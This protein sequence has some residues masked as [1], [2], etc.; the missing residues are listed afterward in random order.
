[1]SQ[2]IWKAQVNADPTHINMPKGATV[3]HAGLDPAEDS[4]IWFVCDPDADTEVRYFTVVGTGHKFASD[5]H[6][7]GTYRY[8]AWYVFHILEL[9]RASTESSDSRPSEDAQGKWRLENEGRPFREAHEAN[10]QM[11]TQEDT[12]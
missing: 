6:H 5:A 12:P 8:D 3:V 4:C 9:G 1:M 2:V 11:R 7:I 10:E